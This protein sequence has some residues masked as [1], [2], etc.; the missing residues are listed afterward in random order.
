VYLFLETEEEKKI[1][2][3]KE[4]NERL[5]L[6][7]KK[8][9]KNILKSKLYNIFNELFINKDEIKKKREN[10]LN[11]LR[12]KMELNIIK[13]KTIN[14]LQKFNE[15]HKPLVS[16]IEK[17]K[18]NK[19]I[20]KFDNKKI[21]ETVLNSNR[22]NMDLF[23]DLYEE[24]EINNNLSNKDFM[25]AVNEFHSDKNSTRMNHL[26]KIIYILRKNDVIWNS[27][28]VFKHIYS[29]QYI[30]DYQISFLINEIENLLKKVTNIVF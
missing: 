24:K 13:S 15:N 7:R 10:E 30:K 27:K 19:E 14:I 9:N 1:R 23:A 26:C 21:N 28:I 6:L 20:I 25:L 29:F 17:I 3:E 5:E 4:K 2:L 8:I 16:L 12:K 11:V 18:K 22:A